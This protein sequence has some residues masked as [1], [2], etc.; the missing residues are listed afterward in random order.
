MKTLYAN[1]AKSVLAN[2]ALSGDTRISISDISKFPEFAGGPGE[3]QY[4]LA[5]IRG[6][7]Y[8]IVYVTG[9]WM[10]NQVTVLRAQEGTTA[11]TWPAGET[12]VVH[13]PMASDHSL[14]QSFETSKQATLVSG[15]NIKTINGTSLLGGGN[16]VIDLIDP[17]SVKITGNQTVTGAKTFTSPTIITGAV[18]AYSDG[19]SIDTTLSTGTTQW[20]TL[21]SLQGSNIP[22]YSRFLLILNTYFMAEIT[23]GRTVHLSTGAWMQYKVVGA[24]GF[25]F[26]HPYKFRIV[27]ITDNIYRL[28]FCFPGVSATTIGVQLRVLEEFAFASASFSGITYPLAVALPATGAGANNTVTVGGPSGVGF[29]A[30]EA[31]LHIKATYVPIVDGSGA[32]G[33]VATETNTATTG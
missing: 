30:L 29:V 16:V 21:C 12:D 33:Q 25:W 31:S 6:N 27:A 2:Q 28:D 11:R 4:K 13:G 8:E 14:F 32:V 23:F 5:L 3:E 19:R 15:T 10:A 22:A 26:S 20:Y 7:D 1:F 9:V 17:N 24:Y 18:G